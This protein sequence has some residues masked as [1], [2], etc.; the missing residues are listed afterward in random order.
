MA[1]TEKTTPPGTILG[2]HGIVNPYEISSP[3]KDYSSEAIY[4]PGVIDQYMRPTEDQAWGML[5]DQHARRSI[6]GTF[7]SDEEGTLARHEKEVLLETQLYE[8]NTPKI[9]VEEANKK[10]PGLNIGMPIHEEIAQMRFKEMQRKQS[11]DDFL[12]RTPLGWGKQLTAGLAAGAMD[13]AQLGLSLATGGVSKAF[14]LA[15]TGIKGLALALGTNVAENFA[16][17]LA[18]RPQLL[19]EGETYTVGDAAQEAIIGGVAGTG[20]HYAGAA[21]FG[22][23]GQ[24]GREALDKVKRG[25]KDPMGG[26]PTD[27]RVKAVI[28]AVA[29][30]E[31]GRPINVAPRVQAELE[32]K[33]GGIAPDSHV[34][35]PSPGEIVDRPMFLP[36]DTETGGAIRVGDK[37]DFGDTY[38]SSGHSANNLGNVRQVNIDGKF[39]DLE[40]PIDSPHGKLISDLI[41]K[42]SGET[43]TAKF[44]KVNDIISEMQARAVAEDPILADALN[45][46]IKQGLKEAG[47]DGFKHDI[48]VRGK[49]TLNAVTLFDNEKAKTVTEFEH[50][51]E[52]L[53][54]AEKMRSQSATPESE[55]VVKN[56]R[57]TTP[58]AEALKEFIESTPTES[59]ALRTVKMQEA[60]LANI[61]ST[62]ENQ[63]LKELIEE[64]LSAKKDLDT[65]QQKELKDAEFLAD[66]FLR[67][68]V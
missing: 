28:D 43:P 16:L 6:F 12:N 49:P 38:I 56:I 52:G 39:I 30:H 48:S 1:K 41:Q 60:K 44:G 61:A 25:P 45:D 31:S 15:T 26:L 29:Q 59:E 24:V 67:G 8:K 40:A 54:I 50:N 5:Y 62:T 13:P 58:E 18:A 19:A 9:S 17:N 3:E 66:C 37:G 21:F 4:Q 33:I 34:Y 47:Y 63:V 65:L 22:K 14:G 35:T 42:I 36:V 11:L 32:A 46:A 23:V 7:F 55:D 68:L 51:P 27:T 53:A 2:E 20:F 64:G 57:E 10:Y